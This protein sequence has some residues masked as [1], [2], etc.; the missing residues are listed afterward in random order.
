MKLG[1]RKFF[2]SFGL[3]SLSVVSTGSLDIPNT[4]V[5]GTSSKE[6]QIA[7]YHRYPQML[8]SY[9]VKLIRQK[10]RFILDKQEALKTQV[11]AQQYVSEVRKKITKSFGPWSKKTPLN[12]LVTGRLSREG[13]WIEKI[14]YE[15]RPDFWVT[16]NLYLPKNSKFPLPAV[17]DTYGH[18]PFGKGGNTYQSFT[19]GLVSKGYIILV[20][21]PL[22]QSERVQYIN[23]DRKSK[24]GKS[25]VLDHFKMG[26]KMVLVGEKL[27]SWFTRDGISPLVGQRT[28]DILQVLALLK[29]YGYTKVHIIGKGLGSLPTTFAALLSGTVEKVTL[30]HALHSFQSIIESIDY[31]WPASAFPFNILQYF[32]LPDCYKELQDKDIKLIDPWCAIMK[33]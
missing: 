21:D 14:I 3:S 13:Y 25:G 1:R 20:F 23:E 28:Y 9:F 18:S 7:P 32:D 6:K 33:E 31:H 8:Q 26:D 2:R 5:S 22:G 29:S 30:K 16:A 11:D 17:L 12:P 27:S 15:S 4:I 10:E 24:L 19:K